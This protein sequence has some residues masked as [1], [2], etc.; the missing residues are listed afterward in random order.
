MATGPMKTGPLV[1]QMALAV[2]SCAVAVSLPWLVGK[3]AS[4]PVPR[5]QE[6]R[7]GVRALPRCPR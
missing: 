4:L 5:Q 1:F 6:R 3:A 2:D 7:D